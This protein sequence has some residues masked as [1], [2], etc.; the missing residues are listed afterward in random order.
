MYETIVLDHVLEADLDEPTSATLVPQD[1]EAV[2]FMHASAVYLISLAPW[3]NELNNCWIHATC[4]AEGPATSAS[5]VQFL[6]KAQD[7]RYSFIVICRD[8]VTGIA[9]ASEG[10]DEY[11]VCSTLQEQVVVA[12]IES[13]VSFS[14][15]PSAKCDVVY[16]SLLE[17]DFTIPG[18]LK[19]APKQVYKPK[20]QIDS[21]QGLQELMQAIKDTRG[22]VDVL[23][24][25]GKQLQ[26]R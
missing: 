10:V 16:E 23:Q 8:V 9:V 15:F 26:Q 18:A 14:L 12:E 20:M 5:S 17:G 6:V 3:I 21:E 13:A 2:L 24:M 1:T 19:P 25:A 11:L 4:G 7:T 22:K